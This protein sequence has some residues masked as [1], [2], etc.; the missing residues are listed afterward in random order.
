[1]IPEIAPRPLIIVAARDDDFVP[2]EA[3]EPFIEAA[4]SEF[5]EIIWTDGRHIRPTRQNELQ[6]LLDVVLSRIERN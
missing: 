2:R 1:W 4:E 5:I 6:Q 3:Q